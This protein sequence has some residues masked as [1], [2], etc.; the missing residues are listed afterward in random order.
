MQRRGA[1]P[2]APERRVWT[3]LGRKLWGRSSLHIHLHRDS[4]G[5]AALTPSA[6]QD[7]SRGSSRGSPEDPHGVTG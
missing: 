2:R 1:K 6:D 7:V 5:P 4:V 3:A